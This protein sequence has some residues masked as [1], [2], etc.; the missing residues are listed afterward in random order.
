MYCEGRGMKKRG[1]EVIRSYQGKGIQLPIRRTAWSAGYD[2]GA[3]ESVD[4]DPG[5]CVFVPTGLKA[6]MQP[7]EVL[8]L[9]IRSGVAG[10]HQL[11]LM[12]SVGIIDADY[13]NN[14]ENE[15]HIILALMNYGENTVHVEKGTRIVQGV[16]M[17]YLVADGDRA[18]AGQARQGGFGSTGES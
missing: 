15:G 13:Y 5:A 2:I 17:N 10:K 4:I 11:I 14:E 18:G 3:A 9:Y 8:Q 16:F 12:N 6:Y 1:F 7:E